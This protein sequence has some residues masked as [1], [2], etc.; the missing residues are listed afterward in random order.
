MWS[1]RAQWAD[2]GYLLAAPNRSTVPGISAFILDM[3]S[4]GV[5]VRPLREMTGTTDFNEV[6]FDEVRVPAANMIGSPG[7]GWKV[8]GVSLA[9]E[10]TGVGSGSWVRIPSAVWSTSP[11][12]TAGAGTGHW[13]T[14]RCASSSAIW[15]PGLASS[16]TW[17]N[18]WGRR[19]LV[20]RSL[21]PMRPW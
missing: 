2:Y 9:E 11:G 3:H 12:D 20:G 6:F 14:V 18:G 1:T 13:T 5:D 10:R 19:R 7:E 15:R 21:R 8:A 16:V 17:V 4:P